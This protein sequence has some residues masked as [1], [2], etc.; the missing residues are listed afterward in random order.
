MPDLQPLSVDI[1]VVSPS[2]DSR[3]EAMRQAWLDRC[4]VYIALRNPTDVTAIFRRSARPEKGGS[5]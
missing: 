2:P 4:P 5:A 1:E 3:V